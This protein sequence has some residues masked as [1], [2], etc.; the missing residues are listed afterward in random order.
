M[1]DRA[2]VILKYVNRTP[3]LASCAQCQHK[4]FTPNTYYNDPLGAERYLREKFDYH[5]CADESQRH[6]RGRLPQ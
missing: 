3:S 4:F 6:G 5:D 1:A 2:F